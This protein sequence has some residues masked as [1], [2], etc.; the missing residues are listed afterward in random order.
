MANYY[1]LSEI[2]K[3]V[4]TISA[5]FHDV[6]HIV[7]PNGHEVTSQNILEAFLKERKISYG[8]IKKCSQ[9][10]MATQM[11]SSPGN[12]VEAIIR[13]ADFSH[14]TDVTYWDLNK[15]LKRE[16]E[17]LNKTTLTEQKW[18]E[19]NLEFLS[20]F[21]FCTDYYDIKFNGILSQRILENLKILEAL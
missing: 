2:E 14:I 16:V 3:T 13:D 12:Q 19:D 1:G 10:I 6:G 9:C 20:T 8:F 17:F 7:E 5:W 4:L 21:S 18:Y 15:S 11:N